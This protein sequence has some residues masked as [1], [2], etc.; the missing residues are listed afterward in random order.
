MEEQ[1]QEAVVK[2]LQAKLDRLPDLESRKVPGTGLNIPIVDPTVSLE[3]NI[4]SCDQEHLWKLANCH[5]SVKD[6]A[7]FMVISTI[8]LKQFLDYTL[9][10]VKRSHCDSLVVE[11]RATDKELGFE[12]FTLGRFPNS[13]NQSRFILC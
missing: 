13:S 8:W 5:G 1:E 7:K 6:V 9:D 10:V 2:D 11:S 3:N 4:K 12:F